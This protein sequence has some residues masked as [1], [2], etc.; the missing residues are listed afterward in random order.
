M[1]ANFVKKGAVGKAVSPNTLIAACFLL[2]TSMMAAKG[3][4]I[5]E[6]AYLME[7]FSVD[8]ATA[9]LANTYYFV[10]YAAVQVILFFV[11]KKMNLQRFLTVTVPIAAVATAFMGLSR[12]IT[13]MYFLFAVCGLFQAGVYCGCNA[14]LT[15]YLPSRYL[16]RANS[17]MNLGYATGTVIAYVFSA[18]CVRFTLWRVP[19]FAMGAF[20]FLAVAFF[21]ICVKGAAGMNEEDKKSVSADTAARFDKPPFITLRGKRSKPLFYAAV[22]VIVFLVTCL[23]YAIN[24]W[25]TTMMVEEHGLSQDVAIYIAVLAPTLIALGPMMTIRYCDKHENFIRGGYVFLT[26]VLPIPLILAFVYGYNAIVT[27]VL[28]VIYIIFVN[29]VKAIGLSVMAFKLRGEVDT[30]EYTSITNAVASLAGGVAPTVAGKIIDA[31]GWRASYF[32]VFAMTL[33][34]V[35]AMICVDAIARKNRKSKQ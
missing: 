9:S 29:G 26:F 13:D 23:Y 14:T 18:V 3:V 11:V 8:K 16:S 19:F 1:K 6:I 34:S 22:L 17:V 21:A 12:G 2:Y 30:A 32:A 35:L 15:K 24:N 27:F 25:I 10:A 33:A 4:F 28:S 7:V 20:L 31:E 5:A